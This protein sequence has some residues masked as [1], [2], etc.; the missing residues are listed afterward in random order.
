MDRKQCPYCG[1][2]LVEGRLR[3]RGGVYFLPREEKPPLTYSKKA[4]EKRGAILLPPEYYSLEQQDYP[5][6]F[7]CRKCKMMLIPYE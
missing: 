7:V 2:P 1:Q 5:E 6:A 3:S 4:M